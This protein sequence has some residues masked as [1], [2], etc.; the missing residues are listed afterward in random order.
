MVGK[1]L[2][3][4]FGTTLTRSIAVVTL[5]AVFVAI[6]NQ[7][8][9]ARPLALHVNG[10]SGH[11]RGNCLSSIAPCAT[12][13]YALSQAPAGARIRVAAGT[14]HEQLNIT[15]SVTI[16]G[17]SP[18]TTTIEPATVVQNDVEPDSSTP[19]FAIVDVHNPSQ[20]VTNVN[21]EN[22]TVNGAAAGA[23][24]FNSCSDNFP[25]VYYHNASG[26]LKRVH[27]IN[28]QEAPALTPTSLFGCQTGVGM[29]VLVHADSGFASNVAMKYVIVNKYQKGGILCFDLGTVCSLG[30]VAVTGIGPTTLTAQNGVQIW[31]TGSFSFVHSK[32]S[33][34]TYS[35]PS[36]PASA[37]GLL[38][39]NA[40]KVSVRNNTVMANDVDVYALEDAAYGL[41]A[42]KGAWSF[43]G[44]TVTNAT[45]D[46][47]SPWNVEG[48]GY[49]DG[50]DIDS[51]SNPVT[52]SG[53]MSKSNFEYGIALFG[54]T[55]VTVSDN[56][57][58]SNYDGIYVG[59]PGSAVSSSTG[60]MITGN[61][62]FLNHN[63]GILADATASE[64]GNTFN[65]NA[66]HHNST[67]E[68]Q[69]RS[70]GGG[71]AGTANTWTGN[72]CGSPHTVSPANVC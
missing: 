53:N 12:I 19:Q 3:H 65:L 44:N 8:A 49:G 39:I 10:A 36:G 42:P 27:V 56:G 35:G 38:I 22:L 31:G 71:T 60:N 1:A 29:G 21:I 48:Q 25:G 64:S 6:A 24:S 32:V 11:D 18:K 70:T 28:L 45:D 41:V 66:V 37:T 7:P 72:L 17:K 58:N 50:L 61:R 13:S 57:A 67:F 16:I 62:V 15:K 51:A 20:N 23:S 59:G 69:D 14:Y 5:A 55:G 47:P 54:T 30:H 43:L 52:I 46:A 40:G 26:L 4:G 63:D 9:G 2:K 33:D 34:N 68:A